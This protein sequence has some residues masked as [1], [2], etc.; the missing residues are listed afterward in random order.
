MT[1]DERARAGLF[2]AMQYPVE[3]PGVSVSNFLRTAKTAIAGEAP[4]L[5]HWVKDVKGR[6]GR[7]GH[8]PDV[9]R[10]QRQ[11]GFSGGEKKRHEI[12]QLS[13]ST[14]RSRSST[15]PTPAWT[16][17]P[18]GWSPRAS[19]GS[20]RGDQEGGLAHHAL[21]ADPA[22]HH[23]DFV[24]VF[25]D[26]RI[27]EEGGPE[28]AEK[29]EAEGYESYAG[30]AVM[31]TVPAPARLERPLDLPAVRAD[32]PMLERTLRG[33]RPLVYLDSAATSQKPTSRCSM[34]SGSTTSVPQ[35]RRASRCP[36]A[37]RG[38][39]GGLRGRPREGRRRSS[40]AGTARS[41]SPATPPRR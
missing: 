33:G 4:K 10:A 11:R 30:E 1:V 25:V 12:L 17:T 19:T 24:H 2:L 5:R 27:A 28:L 7:A 34:P 21:H 22:L 39:D 18:C 29:L 13:C 36:P 16:S 38:G 40:A 14:R 31:A 23:P 35:R 41:C 20:A 6:H 9:R 37:G 26:G 15:R 3:V 8:R 32:F